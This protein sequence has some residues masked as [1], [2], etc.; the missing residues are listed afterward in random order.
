MSW[1]KG[2]RPRR[3]LTDTAVGIASDLVDVTARTG[4]RGQAKT[5]DAVSIHLADA[6]DKTKEAGTRA[7]H[8]VAEKV[9][10]AL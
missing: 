10:D 6:I 1:Q 9:K 4:Q 7:T 2:A 3:R 8:I 5:T